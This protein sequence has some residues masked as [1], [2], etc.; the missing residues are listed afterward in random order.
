[1]SGDEDVGIAMRTDVRVVERGIEAERRARR[2]VW[3]RWG[4]MVRDCGS[5]DCALV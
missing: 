3:R 5:L 4:R 1:M 2:A